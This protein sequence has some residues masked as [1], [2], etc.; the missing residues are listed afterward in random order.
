[1]LPLDEVMSQ[2]AVSSE[3]DDVSFPIVL[4]AWR[5][6]DEALPGTD[7]AEQLMNFVAVMLDHG[8]I[9]VASPYDD[10][11]SVPWPEGGKD[12]ILRR[13]RREWEALD[14][15]VTF[16]DL[17]WFHRPAEAAAPRT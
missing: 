13:L 1:M 3:I 4:N 9:P 7:E 6:V 15:E 8:F 16:L 2:L 5:D 14:H 10:P 17:C 12:A 11:P